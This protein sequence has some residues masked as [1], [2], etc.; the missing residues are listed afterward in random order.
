MPQVIIA[1]ETSRAENHFALTGRRVDLHFRNLNNL[2]DLRFKTLFD[3]QPV[4]ELSS[5]KFK[6]TNDD[7]PLQFYTALIV[8]VIVA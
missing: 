6:T 1:P 5:C 7:S 2:V 4:R 8:L 3:V